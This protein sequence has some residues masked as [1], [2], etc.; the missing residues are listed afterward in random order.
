MPRPVDARLPSAFRRLAHALLAL[1]ALASTATPGLAAADP[2]AAPDSTDHYSLGLAA[3]DEERLGWA[4]LHFERA[5][6][7]DPLDRD[8]ERALDVVRSEARR[9]QLGDAGVARLTGGEPPG[10]FTVR[11]LHS[12]PGH[13]TGWLLLVGVWGFAVLGIVAM[14]LPRGWARDLLWSGA[15]AA[16][17]L[18]AMALAMLILG[19]W[20]LK[21]HGPA[22]VVQGEAVARE[23]PDE[24][25]TRTR[26]SALY[27]GATV[28]LR[29][30]RPGWA[31]IE[32]S[33][34]ATVWVRANAVELL[35]PE[36][37]Y[38]GSAPDRRR[39]DGR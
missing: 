34:G 28:R 19:P 22:V 8:I 5:R 10:L 36:R 2:P 6:L 30:A 24:L 35:V 4:V 17:C 20:S 21:H 12:L 29:E 13:V 32:L 11:L 25:A 26:P 31:R 33:D 3:A 18:A 14:R 1:A 38:S 27:E 15:I 16:G 39:G 9:R 23:A 7:I 37:A